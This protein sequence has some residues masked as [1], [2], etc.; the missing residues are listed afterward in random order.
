MAE[1]AA[2][3]HGKS[4]VRVGRVWR[5][6]ARHTFVEWTVDTMLESDMAHA[7]KSPSNAGMTATD[8]QKNT[9]YFIAKQLPSN[10][11][12]EDFA[13]AL[14]KHFVVT[15]PLVTRAKIGVEQANWERHQQ[16]DRPHAHGYEGHGTGARTA[17]VEY[18][19]VGQLTVHGGVRGW[20]VLKT[21][22]S[23]YEG[24]Y[25]LLA[26]R[27]LGLVCASLQWHAGLSVLLTMESAFQ[28]DLYPAQE[29]DLLI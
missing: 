24:D 19:T 15:Y 2:Q 6:G 5:D 26:V 7:Y 1:L 29:F 27:D 16:G 18:S 23:G 8:T 9:V 11:S 22:Q 20:K 13:I 4:R 3:Q 17:Y 28:L 10:A 25:A 12:P 21:T 14:A